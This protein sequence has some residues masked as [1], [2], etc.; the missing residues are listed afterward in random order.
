MAYKVT[1]TDS[2][3]NDYDNIINYLIDNWGKKSAV[4][5]KKKVS[6]QLRIIRRMP[7]LHRKTE[8]R[9]TTQ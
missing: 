3:R 4:R 1:W 2:A 6:K 8:A 5:F 9:E 7:K